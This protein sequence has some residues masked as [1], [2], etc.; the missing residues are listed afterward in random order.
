[1][2]GA[3]CA[4]LAAGMMQAAAVEGPPAPTCDAWQVHGY[5]IGMSKGEAAVVRKMRGGGEQFRVAEKGYFSGRLIFDERGV[6]G[7]VARLEQRS[8][9]EGN[10]EL[11]RLAES[12]LTNRLGQPLDET[13]SERWSV[14]DGNVVSRAVYWQSEACDSLISLAMSRTRP[15][16][17][18]VDRVSRPVIELRRLSDSRRLRQETDE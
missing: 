17:G 8:R 10:A 6:R 7:Y 16:Q 2:L 1:M 12:V 4:A 9:G 13:A 11:A 18:D 14:L 5:R 3:A 15:G